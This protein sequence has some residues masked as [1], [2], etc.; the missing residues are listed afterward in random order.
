MT[1]P[2]QTASILKRI[3]GTQGLDPLREPRRVRG[4]LTD[5]AP[6]QPARERE[7]LCRA[8][9]STIFERAWQARVR[10]ASS[11]LTGLAQWLTNEHGY[12]TE[13]CHWAVETWTLVLGFQHTPSR[14]RAHAPQPTTTGHPASATP[15]NLHPNSNTR[16]GS[17]YAAGPLPLP[18]PSVVVRVLHDQVTAIVGGEDGRIAAIDLRSG[19]VLD[20]TMGEAG[21]ARPS[22]LLGDMEYDGGCFFFLER[23]PIAQSFFTLGHKGTLKT[24][25]FDGRLRLQESVELLQPHRSRLRSLI[26]KAKGKSRFWASEEMQWSGWSGSNSDPDAT[27][28]IKI[29]GAKLSPNGGAMLCLSDWFGVYRCDLAGRLLDEPVI[30][31]DVKAIEP[32]AADG[33]EIWV[34]RN[35]PSNN[36]LFRYHFGTGNVGPSIA[37]QSGCS[38]RN[39]YTISQRHLRV[40]STVYEIPSLA[41]VPT[42]KLRHFTLWRPTMV[43]SKTFMLVPVCSMLKI[44]NT[45]TL[46]EQGLPLVAGHTENIRSIDSTVNGNYAV[47]IDTQTLRVWDLSARAPI[48]G[49]PTDGDVLRHGLTTDS[50]AVYS[51]GNEKVL[52]L[53]EEHS[54]S[55]VI[56][57]RNRSL[58]WVDLGNRQ[59][60]L[61]GIAAGRETIHLLGY[62]RRKGPPWTGAKGLLAK[63]IG[64]PPPDQHFLHHDS[65]QNGRCV[66][67][68]SVP[69]E[70]ASDIYFDPERNTSSLVD[71]GH[72]RIA[73]LMVGQLAIYDTNRKTLVCHLTDISKPANIAT[74]ETWTL[75]SQLAASAD[76]ARLFV[77]GKDLPIRVYSAIDLS[78]QTEILGSAGEPGLLLPWTNPRYVLFSMKQKHNDELALVI[79]DTS[80]GT[81]LRRIGTVSWRVSI[82][83]NAV[84]LGHGSYLAYIGSRKIDIIDLVTGEVLKDPLAEYDAETIHLSPDRRTVMSTSSDGTARFW[85]LGPAVRDSPERAMKVIRGS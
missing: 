11:S 46:K 69:L 14:E 56:N 82:L 64:A 62:E 66:R 4:L 61:F 54:E 58:T 43:P 19:V 57:M 44:F 63:A 18:F 84:V 79:A 3:L 22:G 28:P 8:L 23:G 65:I 31:G 10:G 75:Y 78:L 36:R 77:R 49:Y 45:N 53:G 76:G 27:E 83:N 37:T 41:V 42:G 15:R 71:L 48:G 72:D 67:E 5:H 16:S 20:S 80:S 52:Q 60:A 33:S 47:S 30:L 85:P 26:I 25:I 32:A 74:H 13:L 81:I 1:S 40:G 24:W 70:G 50:T 73:V 38:W 34:A 17:P 2:Q 39:L 7:V 51:I 59:S 12:T 55:V 9:Q 21:V 35:S 68:A 29:I 6:Q